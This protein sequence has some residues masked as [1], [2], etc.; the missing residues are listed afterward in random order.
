LGSSIKIWV[1]QT[2]KHGRATKS[3]KSIS[4]VDHL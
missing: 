1:S 2:N 4:S 3:W